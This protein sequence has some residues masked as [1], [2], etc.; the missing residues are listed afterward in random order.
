MKSSQIGKDLEILEF[1]RVVNKLL[2]D[3]ECFISV[4]HYHLAIGL[5]TRETSFAS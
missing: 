1:I 3:Y 2:T 4:Q 5:H